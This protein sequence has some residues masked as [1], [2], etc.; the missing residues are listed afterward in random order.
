M[1]H[2]HKFASVLLALVMALSLM[3]PAFATSVG[4]EQPVITL[5][6]NGQIGRASCRERVCL[7]V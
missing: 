6:A 1:K 2:M 7:S 4:E 3:V 5:P